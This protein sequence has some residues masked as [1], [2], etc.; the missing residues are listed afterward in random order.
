MLTTR[1]A[2][3]HRRRLLLLAAA[4]GLAAVGLAGSAGGATRANS[5][6]FSDPV[7]DSGN[8]PDIATVN[9][10]NDDTGKLTF[11]ITIANR[12]Q[13]A[14]ADLVLV[15]MDTDGNPSNGAGGADYGACSP[16]SP[17]CGRDRLVTAEAAFHA[18][19]TSRGVLVAVPVPD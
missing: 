12:P 11:Q 4:V 5:A 16:C 7:G 18:L 6:G 3:R 9:A 14:P 17:S 15:L 8:A 1:K 13:L 10:S 2:P 19:T